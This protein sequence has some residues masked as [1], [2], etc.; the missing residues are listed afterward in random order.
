MKIAL[1]GVTGRAGSR[2]A[3]ELLSRGHSVTGI[4]LH[5]PP[6]THPGLRILRADATKPGSLAPRLVG[7]DAVINATRFVTS[8]A[9]A[10]ITSVKTA[11]V[12]RLPCRRR[13]GQPRGRARQGVD[14]YGWVS[15]G[16]RGR[17]KGRR[18]L[19][20]KT[21]GGARSRLDFPFSL[22]RLRSW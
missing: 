3:T 6:D 22:R 18:A 10:L 12:K 20:R 1:I 15:G 5:V 16:V 2:L 13:S 11:S 21:E 19:S 9:G 17:G 7:H 8:D 4:A 14:G